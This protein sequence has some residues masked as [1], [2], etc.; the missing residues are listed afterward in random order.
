M[1]RLI[2]QAQRNKYNKFGKEFQNIEIGGAYIVDF[3]LGIQYQI[4]DDQR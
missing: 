4:N 2:L 3:E 1:D